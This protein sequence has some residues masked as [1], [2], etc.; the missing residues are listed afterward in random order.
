ML[1][2]KHNLRIRIYD[3][4]DEQQ[5]EKLRFELQLH[6]TFLSPSIRRQVRPATI[7][8]LWMFVGLVKKQWPDVLLTGAETYF[9]EGTG[10]FA[11]EGTVESFGYSNRMEE[12]KSFK[13]SQAMKEF[14]Q[15]VECCFFSRCVALDC[16]K[17][18][19]L[20]QLLD[21]LATARAF[22]NASDLNTAATSYLLL[23]EHKNLVE[24]DALND[25]HYDPI[26][27]DEKDL[28]KL[29]KQPTG[30]ERNCT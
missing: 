14:R 27:L 16:L 26:W 28:K 10:F 7:D 24:S 19:L 30:N 23:K 15:L 20:D 25:K 17:E 9:C 21:P 22:A 3:D 8:F 4:E 29:L 6:V 11:V 13:Y 12:R 18:R 5:N 2:F 1:A